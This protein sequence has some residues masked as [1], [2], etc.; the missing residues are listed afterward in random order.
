MVNP[1]SD[2]AV[3]HPEWIMAVPGREP[4]RSRKQLVLDL[5]LEQVRDYLFERIDALVR[6]YDIAYLKWDH[7]RDVTDP[8]DSRTGRAAVHQATLGLYELLAQLKA[9]HPHLEIESCASGGGRVDLG[10]L[11][12]TDRIWTSDAIDGLERLRIQKHTGL[13]IPPEYLGAHVGGPRSHSTG[14]AQSIDFQAAVA[15]LGHFGIEW[16]L[17]AADPAQL[18]RVAEWV[19]FAKAWRQHIHS[20]VVVHVDERDAA[21]DVRGVV[22]P[23]R[24]AGV[25]VRAQVDTSVDSPPAPVRLVGLDPARRY[26][27]RLGGPSRDCFGE[28]GERE[29]VMSGRVLAEVGIGWPAT[30]PQSA[31]VIEV[32]AI[33]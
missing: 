16:D 1:A 24:G 8:A 26:T 28:E 20:G 9:A 25:F 19:S 32:R 3:Q 29:L 14:R 11:R 15:L 33:A 30:P 7:N 6:E 4:S 17:R 22:A 23:D 2:L 21:Y 18:A 12:H 13:V 27:V 31:S 5:G 10:I